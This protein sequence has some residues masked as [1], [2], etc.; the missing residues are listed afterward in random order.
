MSD[1]PSK[2]K[3][4]FLNALEISSGNARQAYV[5]AQ[6]GG[7]Q[8]LAVEVE[9]L[10]R[11]H[12]E[13]GT[14]LES[15]AGGPTLAMSSSSLSERAGT[16][17]GPYKLLKRIG[18][19]GMGVVFMAE[20][21]RPVQRMVALK[22]INPGMD[23]G[24]VI[25]RFEAERQA[26]A[27]MDHPNIAKV[28]DAGATDTGRPYFVMELVKGVGIT[29]YCDEHHLTPHERLELF[30]PICHALQHAHQKGIIHRDLKPSNVL[31]ALYDGRPVPKV[32]DFGVAKAT[33]PQLTERTML[34][35]LGQVV[36]TLEYMSP[37]QAELN[38][39]DVDTRSDIYSLGVLLYELLTGTTPFERKR[40]KAV[41]FMELLRVI[42]EVEPPKP[43]TRLS[44]T[45]ALPSIA[46][47]RS[48][49]PKKLSGLLRG[50]LDWIVMKCLEKKR[51][52]RYETANA[53]ARD[54]QRHLADEPVEASPPSAVYRIG[55][56]LRKYRTPLQAAAAFVLLLIAATIVSSWQAL[57]ATHARNAEAI[58]HRL[59]DEAT[60]RERAQRQQAQAIA[61]LLESIFSDLQPLDEHLNGKDF[62]AQ[63][64]AQLDNAAANLQ[65][66][67][68]IDPLQRARL[69]FTI[70]WTQEQL[71]EYSK[72][73]NLLRSAFEEQQL[74]LRPDN[75][76]T[77]ETLRA[78]SGASSMNG[79]WNESL[80]LSEELVERETRGRGADDPWT[81][82]DLRTLG[83]AYTSAGRVGDAIKTLSLAHE[84][85]VTRFGP[86]YPQTLSALDDLAAAYATAGRYKEA[87]PKLEQLRDRYTA[88]R[89]ADDRDTIGTLL[90][91]AAAYRGDGRS[92]DA[93]RLADQI[94][95]RLKKARSPSDPIRP[96]TLNQLT[97]LYNNLGKP[98]DAIETLEQ[99]RDQEIRARPAQWIGSQETT[100]DLLALAYRRAGRN[101]EA[102][103]LLEQVR[104]EEVHTFGPT[105]ARTMRTIA[106]LGAA[107]Q[108]TAR[109]TDAQ[110]LYQRTLET[111]QSI[112]GK[113]H[114]STIQA[115]S[116]LATYYLYKEKFSDAKPLWQDV[117]QWCVANAGGDP[118]RGLAPLTAF[119]SMV[120]CCRELKDTDQEAM[121]ITKVRAE[122]KGFLANLETQ[123]Q[124]I[125]S[126]AARVK[127]LSENRIAL[128]RRLGMLPDAEAGY[129]AQLRLDPEDSHVRY[130][131]ACYQC[132]FNQDE[133]YRASR[134]QM[135][136]RY[137]Q[138]T[139]LALGERTAKACLLMP[140]DAEQLKV[141]TRLAD[142][143]VAS[144]QAG[145][146]RYFDLAKGLA[147]Y[148][149]QRFDAAV[150]WLSRSRDAFTHGISTQDPIKREWLNDCEGRATANFFIAMSEHQLGREQKA[151]EALRIARLQ[152]ATEVPKIDSGGA[153]VGSEDWLIVHIAAREAEKTIQT[154]DLTTPA[155]QSTTNAASP[156][157][158]PAGK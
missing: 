45:E 10:L 99:A 66:N 116:L 149:N 90:A 8:S 152:L 68:E 16:I 107:Y 145:L 89:G 84:Q 110:S 22:I 91:L 42:R 54:I 53:L 83:R 119:T 126:P 98:A 63:L 132:Y 39:L 23:T 111:C 148:R 88:L 73:E 120:I 33:G 27:L 3:S 18:E 79:H 7:D 9:A 158:V 49:E 41:A 93:L 115:T 59:A 109:D 156:A 24:Q 61:S 157:T 118:S 47:N 64:I 70:G 60:K 129:L 78:L 14:F 65:T 113:E 140:P 128:Q 151:H 38:Q 106:E 51:S 36:G 85:L 122:L 117:C 46:A 87:I 101:A 40:L 57:R 123:L 138:T 58:Q 135:L 112:A 6:C 153:Q 143:A 20:Q 114:V 34:T 30:I 144:S 74:Y 134:A 104:E 25:A 147:E 67:R 11:Q 105:D 94:K 19:G 28:L 150:D 72:A 155:T 31:V 124:Q 131:L 1:D 4:I 69:R 130:L 108:A 2:A 15:P 48:L 154:D 142:Q 13:L 137:G 50:D 80:K 86:D 56:L 96:D 37:E 82:E 62:R 100:F 97:Q 12:G 92:A 133:D 75:K 29:Q 139:D 26:L 136:H 95:A 71:G 125:G 76:I 102:I 141:L 43:S 127:A 81:L 44:T 77:L 35:E 52:R 32:I 55:K 5:V 21:Q 146:A 17:I 103:P 121:W